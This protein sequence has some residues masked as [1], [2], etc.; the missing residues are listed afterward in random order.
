MPHR[1]PLRSLSSQEREE[2]ARERAREGAIA[3]A[4]YNAAVQAAIARIPELRR[5]RL[6]RAK[7]EGLRAESPQA[8]V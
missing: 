1:R 8:I 4:E 3:T 7:R 2:R 6:A 5:K